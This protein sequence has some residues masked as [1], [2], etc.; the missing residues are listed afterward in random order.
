MFVNMSVRGAVNESVHTYMLGHDPDPGH[1]KVIEVLL[2][3][4]LQAPLRVEDVSK[5]G[6][7]SSVHFC[8]VRYLPS[9]HLARLEQVAGQ[10]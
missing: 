2:W 3:E 10:V 9:D 1:V 4:Q 8:N 6:I 7:I 5:Q